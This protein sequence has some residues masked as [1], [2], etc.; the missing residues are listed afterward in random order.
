ML[1]AGNKEIISQRTGWS[2]RGKTRSP[3]RGSRCGDARSRCGFCCWQSAERGE[4]LP[5]AKRVREREL[6]IR[7]AS[8]GA[9]EGCVPSIP[10]RIVPDSWLAEA[11]V[12]AGGAGACRLLARAPENSPRSRASRSVFQSTGVSAVPPFFGGG[13][14]SEAFTAHTSDSAIAPGLCGRWPWSSELRTAPARGRVQIVAA[15]IADNIGFWWSER[16]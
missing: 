10:Y 5:G 15:R 1:R 8:R 11:W 2:S 4:L 13:V 14:G 16:D 12:L 3:A 6:A 9:P 7:C